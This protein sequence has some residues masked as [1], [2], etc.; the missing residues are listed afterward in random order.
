M[1]SSRWAT[2]P[3]PGSPAARPTITSPSTSPPASAGCGTWAWRSTRP[4]RSSRSARLDGWIDQIYR[5]I[6]R[7][8]KP[9]ENHL[10]ATI[11]LYLYGRSFFLKDKPIA[12]Q[13]Q[14]AVDYFL[15][16]ARKYWLQLADRQ[17]QAHL[18][19]ALKRFGDKTVPQEIMRSIKE[20][21]VSSEE[22]G[23]FWRDLELSWWWFHAPIETQ[24][25]MIEAFDEV[26]N[27]AKAVEDCKVWLLKQKQTQDW[28]T[29]KATADAVYAL[30]AARRQPAGLGR[31][32]RR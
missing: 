28:K 25:M 9:E 3:G 13:H 10:S 32:G 22:L 19:V 15:G 6:L 8:G 12:P 24:A 7:A 16:Q 23:M 11:A 2:G 4:R 14:E 20:R 21:S 31:A 27:D 17:S 29:S 1:P 26:M 5:E 18:A 30:L